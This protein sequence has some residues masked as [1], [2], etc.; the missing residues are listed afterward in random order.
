MKNVL[1]ALLSA[2][3]L[4]LSVG[5]IVLSFIHR[6]DFNF[7][8]RHNM[9]GQGNLGRDLLLIILCF[10]ILYSSFSLIY[11]LSCLFSGNKDK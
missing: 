1:G 6:V 11:Y 7:W 10:V 5:S 9:G 2:G 4:G 8:M 3:A